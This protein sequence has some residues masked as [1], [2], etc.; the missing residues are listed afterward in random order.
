V[1]KIR[2][3]GPLRSG[4][5]AFVALQLVVGVIAAFVVSPSKADAVDV[6]RPGETLLA[7]E[8]APVQGAGPGESIAADAAG[9][10]VPL[11]ASVDDAQ[12]FK[13]LTNPTWEGVPLVFSVLRDQGPW[14]AVRINTRPNGATAWVHRSDVVLRRVPNRIIIEL[15][16][17]RLTVLHS[18][19]VLAQHKVAI[20]SPSAPT[21]VGEFYVDAT[22]HLKNA[23]GPYGV[24]QLSV[25]GF[26]NVHHTFGGGIG[27]I[28]IHGTNNPRAIGGTVSAG[29]I[30]MLNEAWAQVASMAPNG[31]PVSIRA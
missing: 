12:P 31:T 27:Q 22:V 6:P 25:S 11:F 13:T 15:G 5:A 26:S 3:Q 23:G 8:P 21:P 14:L 28:A 17:R 1:D 4:L 9:P 2:H 20:G 29:C 16:E 18:N 7:T 24:G 10:T 19:D 30:R